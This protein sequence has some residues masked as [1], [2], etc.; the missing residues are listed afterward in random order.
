MTVQD[1]VDQFRKHPVSNTSG[2]TELTVV[3][4]NGY[5][6]EIKDVLLIEHTSPEAKHKHTLTF[7][8]SDVCLSKSDGE[9]VQDTTQLYQSLEK[10]QKA[11]M[12]EKQKF[13]NTLTKGPL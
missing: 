6:Y 1:L 8:A 7:Y 9:T 11:L 4:P 10:A 13:Y 12:E 5:E 2:Y 3:G